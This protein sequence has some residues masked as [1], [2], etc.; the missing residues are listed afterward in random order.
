MTAK[1]A[2]QPRT[3]AVRL[4]EDRDTVAEDDVF[5]LG[6]TAGLT[7][8]EGRLC[9]VLFQLAVP[10]VSSFKNGVARAQFPPVGPIV[11]P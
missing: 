11:V 2:G 4:S 1:T 8:L 7:T 10:L 5:P 6:L 3:S 9:P